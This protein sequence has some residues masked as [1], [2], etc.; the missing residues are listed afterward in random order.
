MA[1]PY[2]HWY[3]ETEMIAFRVEFMVKQHEKII[4]KSFLSRDLIG[5]EV[6][7]RDNVR[8]GMIYDIAIKRGYAVGI[9]VGYEKLRPADMINLA[10]VFD[11]LKKKKIKLPKRI[12]IR[13]DDIY[14]V[15][16]DYIVLKQDE[17]K[18][19]DSKKNGIFVAQRIL[20]EQLV[21][22]KGQYI[23]RADELQFFYSVDDK[24]LKISGIITG[25]GALMLRMGIFRLRGFRKLRQKLRRNTIPWELVEHISKKPPT[26]IKLKI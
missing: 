10:K 20:D 15:K 12:F 1:A 14:R 5:M 21:N 11:A 2:A 22:R 18:L 17:Y 26:K 3:I 9:M 24:T 7:S 23:G 19:R 13:W 6:Y 16:D 25:A 8:I 4:T